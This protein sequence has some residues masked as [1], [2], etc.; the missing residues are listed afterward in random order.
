MSLEI[1]KA[2]LLLNSH[3]FT[4][5]CM[6]AAHVLTVLRFTYQTYGGYFMLAGVGADFVAFCLLFLIQANV[7][8]SDSIYEINIVEILDSSSAIVGF[9]TIILLG[10]LLNWLIWETFYIPYDYPVYLFMKKVQTID[11]EI[12]TIGEL[13]NKILTK[14]VKFPDIIDM[15]RNCFGIHDGRQP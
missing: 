9:I 7:S 11:M 8:F 12:S 13:N 3:N 5:H 10:F 14:Y 6:F 2:G 1:T 4:L 15:V